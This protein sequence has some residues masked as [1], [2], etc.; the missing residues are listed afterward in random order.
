MRKLT[1]KNFSVI[2]EAELE[3]GKFTVLIGPQS[4]GKS[5]LCKLAYFLSKQ[6]I[7]YALTA[8]LSKDTFEG[9][10]GTLVS[11]FTSRFPTTTWQ[12]ADSMVRLESFDYWVQISGTAE[13][14]GYEVRIDFS[15][16]FELLFLTLANQI[17]EAP[18]SGAESR[19]YIVEQ[20]EARLNLLLT[21]TFVHHAL[22]IPDGRAFFANQS[23]GFSALKNPDIDPL[24]R[25]FSL[26]VS[27]G[28]SWKPNPIAG[29]KALHVLDEI[30]REM[31]SIAGGHIEGR[32]TSARFRRELDDKIIP[33]TLLSS[34]TQELLPLFNV[35]SQVATGQRDR[36][37]F[38]RP[39][40]LP[41]M[42]RDIILSKGLIYLE[43]PEAN[44]FPDTQYKLVRL[45]ARLSH[46]SILD[47]SWVITT[48]SP[49]ILTA[50]NNLMMAGQLAKEKPELTGEISEIVPENRWVKDGELKAYCIDDGKLKSILSKS[51]LIDGEYLD[52]VSDM[53]ANEFD[54]LLRL[55]YDHTRAS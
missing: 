22:Y 45:F 44:V 52:S 53:I 23:L 21:A 19:K 2:K 14:D 54:S 34:G 17:Q 50:F 16:Q 9:F 46:E 55:E 6:A 42:P 39:N 11:E 3:F 32:N 25:D 51:G 48:H 24:I 30:R 36:I 10:K 27:W 28:D 41:A 26:E 38:P 18:D 29:E 43:E 40:N 13:V 37:V 20:A 15:D 47:F 1:I 12:R 5:L 49:Y 7:D 31:N 4:S 35:L 33:L 8:I